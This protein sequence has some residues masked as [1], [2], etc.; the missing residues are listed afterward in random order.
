MSINPEVFA[1]MGLSDDQIEKITNAAKSAADH[2]RV[3]ASETAKKNLERKHQLE[4]EEARAAAKAE[5]LEEAQLTHDEKLEK[6]RK[7]IEAERNKLTLEKEKI[8]AERTL[9]SKGYSEEQVGQLL[10]V[11]DNLADGTK[12][13]DVVDALAGVLE[14]T[15]TAKVDEAKQGL[16]AGG[17]PPLGGVDGGEQLN[18][19][20]V[21][22]LNKKIETALKEGDTTLATSLTRQLAELSE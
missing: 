11:L 16:L 6:Q 8:A 14:T 2:A 19:V 21:A 12:V 10:G 20:T 13:A 4:L 22:G 3:K 15:I 1:D 18:D 17:T 5:A 7:E 9:T